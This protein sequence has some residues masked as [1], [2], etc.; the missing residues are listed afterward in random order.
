VN[1]ED[2]SSLLRELAPQVLGALIGRHHDSAAERLSSVITS[3]WD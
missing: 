2:L 3:A 1:G